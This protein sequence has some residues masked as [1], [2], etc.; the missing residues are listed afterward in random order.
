LDEKSGFALNVKAF[1]QVTDREAIIGPR[2]G[3]VF[4]A[5]P[6]NLWRAEFGPLQKLRGMMRL[7]EFMVGLFLAKIS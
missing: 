2:S 4:W 7:P 1:A 3:P 6:S 5:P